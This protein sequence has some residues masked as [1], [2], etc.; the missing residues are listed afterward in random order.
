MGRDALLLP[1]LSLSE[2]GRF[3]LHS[4]FNDRDVRGHL[5]NRLM[6]A[7]QELLLFAM[8]SKGEHMTFGTATGLVK[9]LLNRHF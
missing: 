6:R 9:N 2:L 4:L 3:I 7:H 1:F 5:I 8:S